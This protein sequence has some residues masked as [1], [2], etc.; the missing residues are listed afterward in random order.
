MLGLAD[1]AAAMDQVPSVGRP[2]QGNLATGTADERAAV[3]TAV[4]ART[5]ASRCNTV[6]KQDETSHDPDEH[7]S[8][9]FT[10]QRHRVQP[11]ATACEEAGEGDRTLDI[12]L[13]KLTT[14]DANAVDDGVCSSTSGARSSRDSSRNENRPD[15]DNLRRLI[16]AWPSLPQHIREAILA[17]V[18]TGGNRQ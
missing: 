3:E 17:L 12:Q 15:G 8:L 4:A 16:D 7:K 11:S 14:P 10:P 6:R 5:G 13:G 9:S 2:D 18:Q 1:T